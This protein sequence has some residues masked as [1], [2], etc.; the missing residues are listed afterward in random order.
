MTRARKRRTA[1]VLRI[2]KA[3]SYA[4]IDPRSWISTGRIDNTEDAYRWE[5]GIGWIV[6]VSMYGGQ[7]DGV[8]EVP[9][10]T[11]GTDRGNDR[12]EF[13]PPTIGCEVLVG[14]PGG[15]IEQSPVIVGGLTNKG[16]C[17][18]PTKIN[19][20]PIDGEALS[21]NA[22]VVSPYDTEIKKSPHNRREE[23]AGDVHVQAANQVLEA[24]DKV[25]LAVR[26]AKQSFIR[27]DR[28]TDVLGDYVTALAEYCQSAATANLKVYAAINLLAPGTVTP[29]EIQAVVQAVAE[30][31]I[32]RAAYDTAVSTPGDVLSDKIKGD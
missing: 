2:G 15:D 19:Q 32:K 24:A 3:V 10:R 26:N 21:S 20:L 29:D 28:F 31:P 14:I 12:G 22:Q 30:I 18:A 8:D 7:L 13:I 9:C 4:G 25:L 23:F 16:T 1:D 11:M 6:D 17:L 5:P 27:G